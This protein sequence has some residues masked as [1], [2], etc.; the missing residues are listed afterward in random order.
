MAVQTPFMIQICCL[1][2]SPALLAAGIYLTL[3]RIVTTFG[4]ENSR[5][6]GRLYPRIFI[7]C[8]ILALSLQSAGGGIASNAND[9]TAANLGKNIMISGLVAQVAT[10]AV[11]ILLAIDFAFRIWRRSHTLGDAALDPK[12]T[13]L[14]SSFLFCGFL[15]ALSISTLGIF[16][17]CVYRV[18]ELSDGWNGPLISNETLFIVLEG[19]MIV[20]SVLVLNAFHPGWCFKE[21]YEDSVTLDMKSA[22]AEDGKRWRLF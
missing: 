7:P 15:I 8:D 9:D 5:I 4:R 2:V 13:S 6:P 12:Y 3:S 1:T 22:K 20:I 19:V 21:G 10:M 16:V 14:R 17:R 18:A 11:F